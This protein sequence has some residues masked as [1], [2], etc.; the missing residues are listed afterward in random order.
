MVDVW[1]SQSA[2]R[3]HESNWVRAVPGK[4]WKVVM[5]LY[6]P[7]EAWLNE[8]WGPGDPELVN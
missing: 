7:E 3:G 4:G 8:N 5:R 6:G 2:P 1:F